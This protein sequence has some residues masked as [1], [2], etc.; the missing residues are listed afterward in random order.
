MGSGVHTLPCNMGMAEDWGCID[1]GR[2]PC[3]LWKVARGE[4]ELP[5]EAGRAVWGKKG[6][7]DHIYGWVADLIKN[8]VRT[9]S[10]LR[11][12]EG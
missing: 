7:E 2:Y 3:M 5:G 1:C 12:E 9:F 8:G 4:M 6:D 11:P 10:A